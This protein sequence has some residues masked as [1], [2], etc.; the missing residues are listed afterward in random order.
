MSCFVLL[1]INE[2]GIYYISC[3][4]PFIT[5]ILPPST[6]TAD[7]CSPHHVPQ[8]GAAAHSPPCGGDPPSGRGAE[9]QGSRG[10]P[11]SGPRPQGPDT[12]LL[13]P[14]VHE[15]GATHQGSERPRTHRGG[16][17]PIFPSC[18]AWAKVGHTRP[19]EVP[20]AEIGRGGRG[21][22]GGAG[23]GGVSMS[24][25][26]ESGRVSVSSGTQLGGERVPGRTVGR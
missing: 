18:S 13:H 19:W 6:P 15:P 9:V 17:V 3:V 16:C 14:P 5:V 1:R 4:V 7:R 22:G 2:P 21:S 12:C 11:E 20:A 26:T 24:P 10:R 23:L 25:S 8:A